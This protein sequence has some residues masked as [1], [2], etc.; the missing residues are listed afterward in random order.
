MDN[1]KT[2]GR[3][4]GGVASAASTSGGSSL[5]PPSNSSSEKPKVA[6]PKRKS[7]GTEK[8]GVGTHPVASSSSESLK[9][10]LKKTIGKKNAAAASSGESILEPVVNHNPPQQIFGADMN[11]GINPN[12][13]GQDILS[14]LMQPQDPNLV[15][16]IRNLLLLNLPQLA[17]ANFGAAAADGTGLG[18]SDYS[19]R[20]QDV[21]SYM[22]QYAAFAAL[23]SR[24]VDSLGLVMGGGVDQ[25]SHPSTFQNMNQPSY[26]SLNIGNESIN[27][28]AVHENQKCNP[29][30]LQSLMSDDQINVS[31]AGHKSSAGDKNRKSTRVVNIVPKPEQP[32]LHSKES[33]LSHE[34]SVNNSSVS[35][36][37][38]ILNVPSFRPKAYPH[39]LDQLK[40]G[41]HTPNHNL[42]SDGEDD[43][44]NNRIWKNEGEDEAHD[45]EDDEQDVRIDS[46]SSHGIKRESGSLMNFP[47]IKKEALSYA[48]S[49]NSEE[50]NGESLLI[51]KKTG[52][53]S[54]RGTKS[55]YQHNQNEN[56]DNQPSEQTTGDDNNGNR[57]RPKRGRYRNYNRDALAQA[58]QAVKS[59]AMSVHR[60]GTHFGVPH[61]TL[62]YK[63]KDRHLD[64]PAKKRT[65][66]QISNQT[67]ENGSEAADET[68][69]NQTVKKARS[70]STDSTPSL[71]SDTNNNSLASSVSFWPNNTIPHDGSPETVKGGSL[72]V[73]S[74]SPAQQNNS[75]SDTNHNPTVT[76]NFFASNMIRKLQESVLMNQ[77]DDGESPERESSSSLNLDHSR[78]S[79]PMFANISLEKLIK[80][81]LDKKASGGEPRDHSGMDWDVSGVI[82][83]EIK[84]EEEDND[85]KDDSNGSVNSSLAALKEVSGIETDV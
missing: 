27:S 22:T 34:T 4:R 7:T 39:L 47:N 58:V 57:N 17:L 84:H 6:I 45:G 79:P 21:M 59:G 52:N 38:V 62:E 68:S 54:K 36:G 24:G 15:N 10:I 29:F 12:P 33:S 11:F 37:N 5:M 25:S 1:Q 43:A 26:N 76:S 64:R 80:T 14:A 46:K 16:A 83:R 13:V 49:V 28:G 56:S 8:S 2:N 9:Q 63:V 20:I 69:S 72:L 75:N 50:S 82:E 70:S 31:P 41:Q 23:A 18:A 66:A 40:G 55:S 19:N 65:A 35:N 78:S 60:A 73:S 67:P 61:S 51:P 74:S 44:N 30:G 71:T 53:K 77:T 42:F 32:E 81:S 48:S 85:S 3:R